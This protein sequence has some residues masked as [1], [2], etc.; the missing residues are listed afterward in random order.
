M[1]ALPDFRGDLTMMSLA[2]TPLVSRLTGLSTE[3]LREWTSRRALIPADVRPR[4]KGSPA[5]YSWQ[6]VLVL[7]IATALRTQFHVELQAHKSVFDGLRA[8]LLQRSFISLWGKQLAVAGNGGWSFTEGTAADDAIEGDAMFIRL[9]PH[10]EV[11]AIGFALPHRR[12]RLGQ[13]DLFPVQ[14]A[15]N[16]APVPEPASDVSG[17]AL[18]RRRSA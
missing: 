14:V 6:T 18:D 2:P 5:Q 12:S 9:D 4:K 7:R 13:R 17:I 10:L 11:I 16:P 15:A 3:T 8:A 1:G